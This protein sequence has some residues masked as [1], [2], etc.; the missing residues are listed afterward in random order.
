MNARIGRYTKLFRFVFNSRLEEPT[1]DND[2]D[3]D[4]DD[5]TSALERNELVGVHVVQAY[6]SA[7]SANTA[8]LADLQPYTN[9]TV[10]IQ[11]LNE[12]G[13]ESLLNI[14]S[15][16][17]GGWQTTLSAR[18]LESIPEQPARL[19]FS[20]VA[21]SSLNVTWRRPAR[22]NGRLL[23]YE[24]WYE[25]IDSSNATTKIIRQEMTHALDADNHT[26]YIDGLAEREPTEY[27]FRL[28]C[29]TRVGWSMF[30]EARVRTGWQANGPPAPLKP[31][32][33]DLNDTHALLEWRHSDLQQQQQRDKQQQ[34]QQQLFFL[35]EVK[36][37]TLVNN[38]S[39]ASN[40]NAM[41]HAKFG[42]VFKLL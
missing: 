24:L 9:Y 32:Y 37:I 16:A 25:N 26:L 33:T 3:D 39:N 35:V 30:V 41:A 1:V 28:R 8:I 36:F 20:H 21:F 10:H 40:K 29:R 17:A 15:S 31:L 13:D 38:E 5:E 6:F 27:R 7:S 12:H 42:L 34:Q 11:L 18:T 4:D 22:T 19:A 2:D 23:A 14:S